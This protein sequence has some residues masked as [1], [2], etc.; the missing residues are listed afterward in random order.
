MSGKDVFELKGSFDILSSREKQVVIEIL[1]ESKV[2]EIAKSLKL[3]PNTISTIKKNIFYK[4]KVY[5]EI[6]I[7]KIAFKEGIIKA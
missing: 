5:S 6:G 2:T 4:M 1:N 7:V 3:K